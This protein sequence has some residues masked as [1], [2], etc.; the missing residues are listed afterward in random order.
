MKYGLTDDFIHLDTYDPIN[1]S[2]NAY[3]VVKYIDFLIGLIDGSTIVSPEM[4]F[5]D[6]FGWMMHVIDDIW[7]DSSAITLFYN[8]SS[9]NPSYDPTTGALVLKRWVGQQTLVLGCGHEFD[10]YCHHDSLNEYL[11]DINL[12]MLPDL[13]LKACHQSLAKA[14]PEAKGKIH[15]IIFEGLCGDETQVFVDDCLFLLDEGGSVV[16]G[17]RDLHRVV[18]RDGTLYFVE[19]GDDG[20]ELSAVKYHP[21]VPEDVTNKTFGFDIYDWK[22]NLIRNGK[23]IEEMDKEIVTKEEILNFIK[24]KC[25]SHLTQEQITVVQ[26]A[27]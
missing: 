2:N 8:L 3:L 12:T 25:E 5:V 13:C 11:I 14:L 21:W 15:T 24:T 9:E 23:R 6:D 20:V 16:S 22:N 27:P 4:M 1:M 10:G 18:K 17:D 19:F 7:A 26:T